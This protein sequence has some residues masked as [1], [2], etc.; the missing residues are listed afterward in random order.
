MFGNKLKY[1]FI[2]DKYEKEKMYLSYVQAIDQV[3][4]LD[5]MSCILLL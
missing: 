2:D 1:N 3:A 5:D 4:F